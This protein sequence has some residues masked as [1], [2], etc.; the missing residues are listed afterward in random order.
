LFLY[1]E[2][3]ALTVAETFIKVAGDKTDPIKPYMD[4]KKFGDTP[5]NLIEKRAH[6]AAYH[7]ERDRNIGIGLSKEQAAYKARIYAAQQANRWREHVGPPPEMIH[8]VEPR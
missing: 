5:Y 2:P 4:L 7:M 8:I 6:S 1:L 3:A